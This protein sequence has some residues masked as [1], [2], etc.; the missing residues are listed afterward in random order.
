LAFFGGLFLSCSK[1]RCLAYLVWFGRRVVDQGSPGRALDAV[2]APD[3]PTL[4]GPYQTLCARSFL[5]MALND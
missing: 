3:L 1:H 4:S 5:S 2:A